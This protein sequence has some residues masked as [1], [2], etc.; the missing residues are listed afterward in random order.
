MTEG[1]KLQIYDTNYINNINNENDDL[2]EISTTEEIQ[3]IFKKIKKKSKISE[4]KK[5]MN[6]QS[7]NDG[8]KEL[9]ITNENKKANIDDNLSSI[10]NNPIILNIISFIFF[11]NSFKPITKYIKLINIFIFPME[12]IQFIFCFISGLITSFF[13][14]FIILK[15]LSSFHLIY[16][17]FYFIIMFFLHHYHYIGSSHFDQSLIIL[18]IYISI[19]ILCLCILFIIYFVLKY[20]Y[21][22][23]KIKKDNTFINLFVNRWDSSERVKK[24]KK[25]IIINDKYKTGNNNNLNNN[26][27]INNNKIIFNIL[28]LISILLIYI[29]FINYKKNKIFSCNNISLYRGLNDSN[30]L[31]K[32]NTNL[33]D[34]CHFNKPE[35]YCYMDYLINYFDLNPNNKNCSLR[36]AKIEK[37]NFF[38]NLEKNNKNI[39]FKTTK[40]FA[41]P[42]TNLENKYFLKNQI[43]IN[44]FGS[45]VN[46]DIY[47]LDDN[48]NKDNKLPPE[49]ILDF[50][51]DNIYKGEY[52]ELKIN[53]I[54]NKT[55]SE[56]RKKL[57]KDNSF[58]NNIFMLYLDAT[59]RNHF[60][61][62]F[63]KLSS[64]IKNLMIYDE[65]N[66]RKMNAYQYMK[67]TNFATLTQYNIVPMFYG[68]SYKSRKGI[69]HIKY[70]K[71]NGY[72]TGHVIDMCNK[73]QYAINH[74]SKN[75]IDEKEYI[76]WDHENI[77]YLCDGNYFEIDWPYPQEK[78]A[79]STKERCLY[80]HTVSYYM[81]EYAKQFWQKYEN[82]KKYFRMAFNYGHEKTGA[83][84]SNLDDIIYNFFYEFY[85]KGW[86]D[87]TAVFIVSDHGNQNTGIINVINKSLFEY[88]KKMGLFFLIL[89]KNNNI[90][91]FTK[92]L[93][94]NQNVFLTPYDIHDTLIYLSCGKGKNLDELKI[95]FS[96]DGKGSSIL[97]EINEQERN[98]Q[99]Y[100]DDWHLIESCCC[101]GDCLKDDE[102][103]K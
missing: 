78:G 27:Q 103:Q 59:S 71:E 85:D 77:A 9:L 69:N 2:N 82:N 32:E 54:Y 40:K 29:I 79:F 51:E 13:I 58:Y 19:I 16:M 35:G 15:K 21:I 70:L 76:E 46:Q 26:N 36:D 23:G 95:M 48:K 34:Q 10:K 5:E 17:I 20:Y 50:S 28:F 100:E 43:N 38:M 99:K 97:F 80:G 88:E 11:Y 60:Q 4:T 89:S 45:L 64:F 25:D 94:N 84:L 52:P 7:K 72:I 67:Y 93:E 30:I 65:T 33:Q 39:N 74:N 42:Y 92:N 91:Q 56:S 31:L 6:I 55:L 61:R 81:I 102:Q 101:C 1:M 8:Y 44:N 18:Y 47:D 57:E 87:N 3:N 68:N 53:L 96:R 98:C 37:K 14:S 75:E 24:T 12:I 90:K 62:S 41:F 49:V 73:E 83:V 86:F 22:K 66:T 63:P